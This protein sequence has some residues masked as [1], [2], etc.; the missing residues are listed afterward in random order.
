MW[1]CRGLLYHMPGVSGHL[2]S[3]PW[4]R[5]L[6]N[7]EAL[8]SKLQFSWYL[9]HSFKKA[10][11]LQS[12]HIHLPASQEPCLPWL[13][14]SVTTELDP[15]PTD[16]THHLPKG[17]NLV[18][19]A[20]PNHGPPCGGSTTFPEQTTPG[21]LNK[22]RALWIQT[23]GMT[24]AM[25]S[26]LCPWAWNRNKM[27]VPWHLISNNPEGEPWHS[28]SWTWYFRMACPISLKFT[29]WNLNPQSDRIQNHWVD[30]RSR[31]T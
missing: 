22:V 28:V 30:V 10:A 19:Q 26:R 2:V 21:Y 1:E 8:T 24:M 14:P 3:S 12:S 5:Q 27:H 31:G 11:L 23:V 4:T 18:C 20:S 6:N 15:K 29:C 25:R 9:P 13:P 16:K 7:F 17:R